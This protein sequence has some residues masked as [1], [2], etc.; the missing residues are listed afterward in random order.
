[1]KAINHPTQGLMLV[2][3]EAVTDPTVTFPFV[4][5]APPTTQ[6]GETANS[7]LSIIDGV[8]HRVW[9]VTALPLRAVS[10]YTIKKRVIPAEWAALKA[11]IALDPDAAENW[12]ITQEIDPEHPQTKQV[13]AYLQAQ[14]QLQTPLWQIFAP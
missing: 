7:T 5:A 13:I 4:D 10:K 8:V 1:M 3:N 6:P 11:A 12:D 14:G 2:A 9:T